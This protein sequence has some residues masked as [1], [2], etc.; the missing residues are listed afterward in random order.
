MVCP[1]TTPDGVL[2]QVVLDALVQVVVTQR[3]LVQAQL[4][5]CKSSLR[6]YSFIVDTH[7][8]LNDLTQQSSLSCERRSK[9]NEV[10]Y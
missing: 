2:D 4:Y 8:E 1:T 5:G 6:Y 9:S 7:L 3:S 10:H